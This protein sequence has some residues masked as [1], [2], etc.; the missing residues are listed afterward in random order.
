MVSVS[1]KQEG[2][3]YRRETGDSL[4]RVVVA[5]RPYDFQSFSLTRFPYIEATIAFTSIT[6][7]VCCFSP[8]KDH[9]NAQK[10]NPQS[11]GS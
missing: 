6:S 8:S 3:E 7:L 5:F 4:Q 9:V 10:C 2:K 1:K 11:N